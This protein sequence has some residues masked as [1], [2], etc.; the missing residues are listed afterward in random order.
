MPMAFVQ[1]ISSI[2]HS[3]FTLVYVKVLLSQASCFS[4]CLVARKSSNVRQQ[5]PVCLDGLAREK[6]RGLPWSG[7]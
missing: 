4:T 5:L 3:I 7:G 1:L 6:L 2:S